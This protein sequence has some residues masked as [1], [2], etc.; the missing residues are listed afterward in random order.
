MPSAQITIN[1]DPEIAAAFFKA[2][3]EDRRKCELLLGLHLK[4]LLL[5][6]P[7]ALREVI[8]EISR[9]AQARGLTPEILDSILK[10]E[11]P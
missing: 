7:R 9:N 10:D 11:C 5:M 1:V 8:D 6:K 3:A 4:E 2:S